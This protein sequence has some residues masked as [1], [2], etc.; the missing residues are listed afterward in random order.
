MVRYCT[1]DGMVLETCILSNIFWVGVFLEQSRAE[2]GYGSVRE[3]YR[4]HSHQPKGVQEGERNVRL[5]YK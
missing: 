3:C 1:V 4:L 2:N 5:E